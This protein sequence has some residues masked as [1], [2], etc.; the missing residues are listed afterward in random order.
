MTECSST[1]TTLPVLAADSATRSASSG[2]TVWRFRTSQSIPSAA[3]V[4]AASSAEE[5]MRPV[6]VTVTSAPSRSTTPRPTSKR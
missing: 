1:V 4:S 2:F 3:S 5:T 6:A